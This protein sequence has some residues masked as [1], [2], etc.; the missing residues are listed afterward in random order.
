MTRARRLTTGAVYD[1]LQ[2]YFGLGGY[3]Y[4]LS[5]TPYWKV[6]RTEIGKLERSLFKK[7]VRLADLALAAE[8]AHH[9]RLSITR[10]HQLYGHINAALAWDRAR[11]LAASNLDVQELLDEALAYEREFAD[12]PWLSQLARAQGPELEEVLN[13]WRTER[14]H[15]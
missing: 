12:S 10:T 3:E 6:R 5:S 2:R 13:Q 4:G 11:A 1:T 14:L 9:Q 15:L 8:Y 7:K